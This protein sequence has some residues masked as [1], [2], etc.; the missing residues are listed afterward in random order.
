MKELS[1]VKEFVFDG[2]RFYGKACTYKN[3]NFAIQL[4][5]ASTDQYVTMAT[6]NLDFTVNQGFAYI[7]DYSENK[8]LLAVLED[9]GIVTEVVGHT[10][11]GFELLPLCRINEELLQH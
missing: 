2:C 9:A 4:I 6:T 3:G 5:K 11:S 1:K 10:A 8:G 7:K